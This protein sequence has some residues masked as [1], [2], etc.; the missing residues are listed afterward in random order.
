VVDLLQGAGYR[1]E[2]ASW[3]PE[4]VQRLE[5]RGGT[6]DVLITDWVM[7]GPLQGR[8]LALKA[9]SRWPHLPVILMTGFAAESLDGVVGKGV[10]LLA[11]PFRFEVL[12]QLIEDLLEERTGAPAPAEPV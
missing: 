3:G 6:L 11:K 8:E 5:A 12:L 7:P 10:Q 2:T 1:V 4:A 9:R